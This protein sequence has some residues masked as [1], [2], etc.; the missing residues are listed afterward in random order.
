MSNTPDRWV[1]PGC[2][3]NN[4]MTAQQCFRCHA[5]RPSRH[6]AERPAPVIPQQQPPPVRPAAKTD[7]CAVLANAFGFLSL[8]VLPL[9]FGAAALILGGVSI[10][11]IKDNPLLKGKPQAYLGGALGGISILWWLH[12]TGN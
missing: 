8:L 9:V 7:L 11:R 5:P 4:F 6:L 2:R 1:C 3:A 10:A 12:S